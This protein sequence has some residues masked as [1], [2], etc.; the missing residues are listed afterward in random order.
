M[1]RQVVDEPWW[2]RIGPGSEAFLTK[3]LQHLVFVL[4]ADL[5]GPD[6]KAVIRDRLHGRDHILRTRAKGRKLLFGWGLRCVMPLQKL[7]RQRTVRL[8]SVA[9]RVV[10]ENAFSETRRL[11]QA[12]GARDD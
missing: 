2:M 4:I 9:A 5:Q 10:L 1:R 3:S 11:A 7:C 8:G 12:N 6:R